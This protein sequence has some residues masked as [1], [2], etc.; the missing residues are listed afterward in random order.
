M[1]VARIVRE[2]DPLRILLFGS[3]ARGT[4]KPHSDIDLLVVF[5]SVANVQETAV[6][7]RRAL[8]GLGFAKDILVTTP[9]EMQRCEHLPGHVLHY[10]IPEA[11][12]LYERA[13]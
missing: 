12:V 7:I 2:Y 3:R 4:A 13:A 8:R 6:G 10:A 9:R 1:M 11:R 5:A